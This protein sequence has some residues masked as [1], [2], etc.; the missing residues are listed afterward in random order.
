MHIVWEGVNDFYASATSKAD[1][2]IIGSTAE[3]QESDFTDMKKLGDELGISE[4]EIS[5]IIEK[6]NELYKDFYL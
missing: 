1:D 4:E 6:G 3:F 5:E 2:I